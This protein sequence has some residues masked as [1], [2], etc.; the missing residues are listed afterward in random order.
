MLDHRAIID[1]IV[2]A[3]VDVAEL[4]EAPPPR[5]RR[6]EV[7]A[8]RY[9][10]GQRVRDRVTGKEVEVLAGTRRTAPVQAARG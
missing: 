4:R 8:L 6:E 2:E 10:P 7:L 5:P 1:R 9:R 3:T